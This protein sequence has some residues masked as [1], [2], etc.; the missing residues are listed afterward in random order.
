MRLQSPDDDIDGETFTLPQKSAIRKEIKSIIER[1]HRSPNPVEIALPS[2]ADAVA[3]LAS[4]A[5]DP[6]VHEN[7]DTPLSMVVQNRQMQIQEQRL[8]NKS[9]QEELENTLNEYKRSQPVPI[10]S[11]STLESIIKKEMHLFEYGGSRGKYLQFA[12]DCL[13][14]MVPTSVESERAF[15][16]AGF[17]A[18]H[19]RSRL[20]D[21]TIDTLCFLRSFFQKHD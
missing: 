13:L 18:S 9:L 4:V 15:S 19:I 10:P 11:T 12:Y 16:S 1:L 17:L 2:P 21:G 8:F 7:D 20:S 14:S 5:P 3:S 6:P